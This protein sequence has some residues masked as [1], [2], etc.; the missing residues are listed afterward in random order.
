M[1]KI[2]LIT[3]P[4]STNYG[5]IIQ[6]VVLQDF[7]QAIGYETILINRRHHESLPKKILTNF[8]E[9]YSPIDF[10]DLKFRKKMAKDVHAFIL[11][12]VHPVSKKIYNDKE[13]KNLVSTEKLDA[14]IVGSD[15][16]WRID[17]MRD[18]YKNA[19]LNF[20]TSPVKKISYAASFGKSDWNFPDK[21]NEIQEMLNKFDNISVREDSGIDLLQNEFGIDMAELVVDPTLLM[22]AEYYKKHLP[23]DV[24]NGGKGIFSYVLDKTPFRTEVIENIEKELQLSSHSIAISKDFNELKKNPNYKLPKLEEW[25][26]GFYEADFVVTDS[27]HGTIFSIIFNKPFLSIAN[28]KRGVTRFTSVLNQLNI[29]NRLIFDDTAFDYQNALKPIDYQ[30]VNKTLQVWKDKSEDFLINAIEK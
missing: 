9:N 16:V 25:L 23:K 26:K 29:E 27:F 1:K 15:Q 10:K 8:I 21:T 28:K 2:G 11:Q 7:L 5:G 14:V 17:Y 4:L 19:F 13:L 18:L 3:M 12:N 20:V 6:I 30:Q 24:Q 22:S